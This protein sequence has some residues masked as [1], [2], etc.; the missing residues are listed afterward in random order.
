MNRRVSPVYVGQGLEASSSLEVVSLAKDGDERSFEM[1]LRPLLLPAYKLACVMLHDPQAAEDAVQEAALKSW[2]KLDQL[3][4][5]AAMQPWFF[6]IVANEC[7]SARKARWW[8]VLTGY[9]ADREVESHSDGVD[10]GTDVRRA[11]NRLSDQGR[12]VVVLHYYFDMSLEEIAVVI[13]RRPAAVRS[14]LYRS[15]D[16]LRMQGGLGDLR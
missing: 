11:L 6:G 1:L 5:G 3:R 16:R 9:V 7:R 13:K 10:R 4:P 14:R 2:R 12:L 15:I 8:S